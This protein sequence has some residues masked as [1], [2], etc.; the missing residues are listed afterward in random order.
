M[1]HV[2]LEARARQM[3]APIALALSAFYASLGV[4]WTAGGAGFPFGR[5]DVGGPESG[6]LLSGLDQSEGGPTVAAI[7]TGAALAATAMCRRHAG[8]ARIAI[9]ASGCVVVALLLCVAMDARSITLLPPLGLVGWTAIEDWPNL[10]QLLLGL[11]ALAWIAATAVYAGD[12]QPTAPGAR[13]R[14]VKIGSAATVV[15]VLCPL[16]YA[17]IRVSW[18]IGRPIGAPESFV[19]MLERNQPGVAAMEAVLAGFACVG[20]LLTAGLVMR[21]GRIFPAWVPRLGGRPVP[22]RF[23]L[24]FGTC[25]AVAIF[26]FGRGAW[27]DA[28]GLHVAGAD[29]ELQAWGLDIDRPAF[30]GVDGLGWLFPVWALALGVALIGYHHRRCTH[31]GTPTDAIAVASRP[32]RV[33]GALVVSLLAVAAAI[34]VLPAVGDTDGWVETQSPA[35]PAP[36]GPS[37]VG[38]RAVHLIDAER[39]DPLVPSTPHRELMVTVHYPADRDRGW[40]EDLALAPYTSEQVADRWG[41]SMNEAM[42]IR[43]DRLN[44][45]FRTHAREHAPVAAGRHPVVLYTPPP[46]APRFVATS[47]AQDLASHG[48]IVVAVDHTYESP[49]VEFPGRRLEEARTDWRSAPTA[50]RSRLMRIRADDIRFVATHLHMLDDELAASTDADRIA[51]VG[52]VSPLREVAPLRL[53]VPLDLTYGDA[54][55]YQPTAAAVVR[56]AHVRRSVRADL[57]AGLRG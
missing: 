15:A 9:V 54:A 19:E 3:A 36:T 26:P 18:A 5:N 16:P 35:L 11:G 38:V 56:E 46:G 52:Y 49:L 13:R 8:R 29:D 47:L 41:Q 12:T 44:W 20:A 42:R 22:R 17:V 28:L 30:W 43:H 7:A 48:Y 23:P 1:V 21:W 27:N 32:S 53:V 50:T 2:E 37:P 33:S 25:A 4:Y 40:L 10:N 24:A 39:A 57:D 31:D 6:S 51:A 55:L 45:Q 34:A 14:W